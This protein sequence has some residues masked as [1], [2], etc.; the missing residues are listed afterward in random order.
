METRL[1]S[2]RQEVI[3]FLLRF[4]DTI[5]EHLCSNSKIVWEEVLGRT[6]AACSPT[7]QPPATKTVLLMPYVLFAA[8]HR[9]HV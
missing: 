2:S 5:A 7:A 3:P 9:S 1:T 6:H 4:L 8:S